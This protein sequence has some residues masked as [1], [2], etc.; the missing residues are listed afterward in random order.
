MH[1]VKLLSVGAAC[2]LAALAMTPMFTEG[3]PPCATTTVLPHA[4]GPDVQVATPAPIARASDSR[5]DEYQALL[6]QSEE[7]LRQWPGYTATFVQQVSKDGILHDV[8]EIDVKVRHEPFS[9]YMKWREKGQEVLYVDGENDGRLLAR[10]TRGLFQRT[11]KLPPASRIAM[12]DARQPVT[13]VGLLGLVVNARRELHSCPSLAGVGCEVSL[14]EVAGQPVRKYHVTFAAP[15]VHAT[16]SYCDV[17]FRDDAPVPVS[18]T[19]H[20]WTADG[21]P[22]EMLEYYWYHSVRTE[23]AVTD[24]DFD[25]ANADYAF[26]K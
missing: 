26:R 3:T 16:Y 24:H 10:R 23:P 18:I 25:P 4:A 19:C 5:L 12:L 15:E 14:A 21:K 2:G 13:E 9:V 8:Q 17:C 20:G 7:H 22:G 1:N 6:N 11:V